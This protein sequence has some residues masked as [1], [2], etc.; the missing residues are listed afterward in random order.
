[1]RAGF[2]PSAHKGRLNAPRIDCHH[3]RLPPKVLGNLAQ[4]LGR[5]NRRSIHGHL[6]GPG[7]EQALRILEGPH[8]SAHGQRYEKPACHPVH[9][10]H[11]GG[12]ALA[13]SR[14]IQHD[15]LIRPFAVICLRQFAGISGIAKIHKL[16]AFDHSAVLAIEAGDDALCEH[17]G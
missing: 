11:Q 6:I 13:G 1:M 4:N 12:A 7:G 9:G 2:G 14:D 15:Q 8:A 16:D 5:F 17:G 10:I 3:Q